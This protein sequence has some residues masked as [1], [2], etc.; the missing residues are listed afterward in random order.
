MDE[1]VKRLEQMQNRSAAVNI[2]AGLRHVDAPETIVQATRSAFGDHI[3]VFVGNAGFELVKRLGTI[4]VDDF[5]LRLRPYC[6]SYSP[7]VPGGLA[8]LTGAW[9]NH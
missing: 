5:L 3:D 1:L 4:S 8:L 9:A 6:P 2:Q 7:H